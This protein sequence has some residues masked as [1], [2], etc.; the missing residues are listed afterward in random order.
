MK[1]SRSTFDPSAECVAAAQQ[2]KKKK[3]IRFRSHKVTVLAVDSSKRAPKG[4]YRKEL[5]K[6]GMEK[7]VEIKRNFS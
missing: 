4:K 2:K 6:N 7:V 3:S 5:K 1:R